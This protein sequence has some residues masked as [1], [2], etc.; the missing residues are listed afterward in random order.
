ML[1]NMEKIG[2]R[3]RQCATQPP[4]ANP[5][6]WRI[7][8]PPQQTTETTAGMVCRNPKRGS[9]PRRQGVFCW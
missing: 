1:K 3:A 7:A 6:L 9:L 4:A 8:N 5:P 2:G